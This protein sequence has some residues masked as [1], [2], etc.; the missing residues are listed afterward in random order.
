MTAELF[1]SETGS[2]ANGRA[3]A[4][5]MWMSRKFFLLPG[6]FLTKNS[7]ITSKKNF[8]KSA[9]CVL[10]LLVAPLALPNVFASRQIRDMQAAMLAIPRCF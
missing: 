7:K 4:N 6:I 10:D 8:K 3:T 1:G 9:E 5:K 2:G